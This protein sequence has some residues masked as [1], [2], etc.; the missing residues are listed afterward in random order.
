M[1]FTGSVSNGKGGVEGGGGSTLLSDQRTGIRRTAQSEESERD[2]GVAGSPETVC[3]TRGGVLLRTQ[4]EGTN[5]RS[6]GL[7]LDSVTL[8]CE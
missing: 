8:L 1:G 7:H 3:S 4:S 6:S 2:W 5:Q